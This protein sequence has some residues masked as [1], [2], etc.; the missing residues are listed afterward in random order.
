[1]SLLYDMHHSPANTQQLQLAFSVMGKEQLAH[2]RNIVGHNIKL[3]A[4]AVVNL[5]RDSV[6]AQFDEREIQ[7]GDLAGLEEHPRQ[8]CGYDFNCV[9][10]Q[11]A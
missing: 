10:L 6:A 5:L 9:A 7:I 1:M 3:R 2:Q 4:V 8:R 11:A